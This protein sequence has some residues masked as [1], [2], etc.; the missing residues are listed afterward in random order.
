MTTVTSPLSA[1]AAHERWHQDRLAAVT[2]P[3]GSLALVETRWYPPATPIPAGELEAAGGPSITVTTLEREDLVTGLPQHGLRR[4]DAEAAGR[5]G[6]AGI[7]LFP[8][9]PAWVLE[10]TW[11]P[12]P[13]ERTVAFEHIR[14][15]G[16]TREHATPGDVA[17]RI[18]GADYRLAAVDGGDALLL[19][20][21]DATNGEE[22]YAAGR[23][24]Q[25]ERPAGAA[26]GPATVLLDFNRAYVPPCGF[27]SEFNCPL[28]PASNRV[29]AP[30][31]AGERF[32]RFADGQHSGS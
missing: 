8:Y 27:S 18:A 12:S 3:Q 13:E 1:V 31:R 19:V 15:G 17:V 25:A 14:D 6:F 22:T 4:W 30:V 24:L 28:P 10:G 21:A 16:H 20:F 29:A 7:D 32:P 2:G 11:L 26:D 9:D 5:R 23:F